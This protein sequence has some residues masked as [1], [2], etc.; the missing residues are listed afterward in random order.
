M[1]GSSTGNGWL[2]NVAYSALNVRIPLELIW[3][4]EFKICFNLMYNS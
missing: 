2:E 3:D 4:G 1:L